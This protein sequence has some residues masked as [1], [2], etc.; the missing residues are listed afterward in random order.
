VLAAVLLALLAARRRVLA[1]LD[2]AEGRLRAAQKAI[3]PGGGEA[4]L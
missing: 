3:G 4:D 1:A 2:E